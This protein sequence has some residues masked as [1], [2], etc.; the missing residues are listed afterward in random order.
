MLRNNKHLRAAGWLLAAAL[1]A[2]P[3][4][5][6]GGDD[7]GGGGGDEIEV[8][9]R[10]PVG[11]PTF[12]RGPL[13]NID[14]RVP[15][16]A[17]T[18]LK[19]LLYA[20]YGATGDEM[21]SLGRIDEDR[22]GNV[23]LRVRETL[24]E[25]PVENAELIVHIDPAGAVFAVSGR[26]AAARDDLPRTPE[27]DP[28]QATEIAALE[29][30]IEAWEPIDESMLT[31]VLGQ[32][33]GLVHLAWRSKIEYQ[34]AAG[35]EADYLYAD[36]LTGNL[37][38]RHPTIHRVKAWQTFSAN[39]LWFLPGNLLCTDNGWCGNQV[40][41]NAHDNT[42]DTYDYFFFRFGRDSVDGQGFNLRSTVDYRILYNNAFWNGT[43]FVYGDGG[44]N[45]QPFGNAVD[46][47]AHE[48]THAMTEFRTGLVYMDESGA[49]NEAFSDIFGAAVDA[50]TGAAPG[51]VWSMG[52]D[53]GTPIRF[54]DDPRAA[55]D[56]DYYPN[57][58][59]GSNDNGGVH[60]NSGIANLAFHLM[61]DGG[62]HPHGETT[63]VVPAIGL[64]AAEQ[65][66]YDAQDYLGP[67]SDFA[68]ANNAT[69][70]AARVNFGLLSPE[71]QSVREAWCAVGVNG[72]ANF[73][74]NNFGYDSG[75]GGWRVD[76]HPRTVADV[77]GDGMDDV[78]GFGGAGVYVALS[79]GGCF[80]PTQLWL[81]NFGYD[82]AAGGY[83]VDLH[84][85]MLADVNGDGMDDAVAFGGAGVY[86]ALSTGS[87]FAPASL[88]LGNL[89]R[90][91]AAGG[92]RVE[93]HPRMTADVNNDGRADV[94]GFGGAGV[95]VARSTGTGFTPAT[96]WIGDFGFDA[97]AGGYRIDQ[98]PRMMADVDGDGR[99][100]AVAFGGAGVFVARSTGTG[101]TPAS[102]WI[103]NYGFDLG[104]GGWRVDQH[105]RMMADVNGDG[106]DDVVGYG[107]AGPYLATSTG[108]GFNAAVLRVNNLGQD[109]G[110]GGWRVDKHPRMT[111]DMDGN[112]NADMVGFGGAG[113][114]LF[115]N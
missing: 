22:Q 84:P 94:V 58:Y 64:A 75:A 93:N 104:A 26:F 95:F 109:F 115:H 78:V 33:D 81:T 76:K 96:V 2:S 77:N 52:E 36:A 61:V 25:L 69:L 39:Y 43:Q 5:A 1:L 4:L 7:G 16:S 15:E 97:G 18:W 91:A 29:A 82:A 54:L 67:L 98:H 37:V 106:R 55:G 6:K 108:S 65:I 21:L 105:P 35:L 74:I 47:V 17:V 100:D 32:W 80:A 24:Y 20:E 79:Q 83:R 10:D 72:L 87:S 28:Q 30:E 38:A 70:E 19:E 63:N 57:R 13:G 14:P 59:I 60:T 99:D 62:T 56:R 34:S 40:A 8:L 42:S 23:H 103:N 112:G 86:V 88:W 111:G 101:F 41:Q 45:T 68:A 9:A 66:F 11:A 92:W 53:I 12:I 49:V 114:Y 48:V 31:Y 3:A 102:L 71:Y 113:V 46:V 89:G 51:D 90:D 44:F 50:F 73:G 110:A 27:L 85:R 107:G